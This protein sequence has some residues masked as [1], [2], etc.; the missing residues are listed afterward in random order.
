MD[1][2]NPLFKIM[3]PFSRW[4]PSVLENVINIFSVSECTNNDP[5]LIEVINNKFTKNINKNC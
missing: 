2:F 5:E 1:E 4:K 3:R